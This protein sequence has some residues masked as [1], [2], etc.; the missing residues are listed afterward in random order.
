MWERIAD[1]LASALSRN[2]AE[3]ALLKAKEQNKQ[4][5]EYLEVILDTV[6]AA[7]VISTR[8]DGKISYANR[9]AFELCGFDIS[10]LSLEANLAKVKPTKLDGSPY[11]VG[12]LFA[13][14]I[15]KNG[16]AV[17]DEELMIKRADGTEIL[18]IAS[19][20]PVYDTNRKIVSIIVAFEDITKR[21]IAENKLKEYQR[22]LEK[23][24]EE[25]TKQLK[26]SERLAA[27]GATAGMVGH[28]IRNPLQAIIS[29]VYLA[30]TELASTPES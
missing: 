18:I 12:E 28:D 10:G 29:D 21:M 9:R 14:R 8:P 3:E 13:N 22:N 1:R 30:K 24:V 5:M 19:A 15:L 20:A 11:P 7:V 23:L 25:R 2:I 4:G 26:D 16:Q 6:P 27:I 17:H